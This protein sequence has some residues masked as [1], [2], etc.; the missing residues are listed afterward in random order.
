MT[1]TKALKCPFIN[2]TKECR[3][4]ARL[5][6]SCSCLQL[7]VDEPDCYDLTVEQHLKLNKVFAEL[8]KKV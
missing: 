7:G 5:G 3:F 8:K 1:I 2:R 6:Y 4:A